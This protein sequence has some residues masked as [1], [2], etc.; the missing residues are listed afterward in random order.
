M[1]SVKTRRLVFLVLATAV[2]SFPARAPAAQVWFVGDDGL[3]S[4]QRRGA[5]VRTSVR[6]LL[7]GPTRAERALGLRTAIPRGVPVLGLEV[8]R[9]VVT[10]D[11]GARVA[12]GS[13]AS[14]LQARLGQLVR[15]VV[16]VPGVRGVRLR[17]NGGV[18]LGL[19][20]GYD[21]RRTLTP[22]TV[23]DVARPTVREL[24]ALLADLGFAGAGSATGV[25]DERTGVAT[26]AFQKWA[27]LPRD[28]R[29]AP[30]T[31]S[32]LLRAA[33]PRPVQR[34]GAGK[35][36]EVL[37]DRQL[38]LLIADD[39]VERAV[40]ISTGANGLTPVGSFSVYRKE[41]MSW[42]LPFSVWMPW[43]S[44][45]VGGIAFHEYPIVP[46]YPASHG[47]VRVSR[48]DAQALYAFATYGTP[49]RVWSSS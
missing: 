40:H 25:E 28:G 1:S 12:A 29:L 15:T 13:D 34:V 22:R 31:I 39:R 21:L 26:L 18:P 23:Q 11:L 38:A 44:Y 8:R 36:I 41:T 7:A 48:F 9:R 27:G 2:L 17:V 35:R 4:A 20:P 10:L 3:A 46:A 5:G 37:L 6:A 14:S 49:V 47:C 42:S 43:A 19:F 30:A 32:A 45:F 33:R 16:G 24:Q